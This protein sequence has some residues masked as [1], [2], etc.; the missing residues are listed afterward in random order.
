MS[1]DSN[2]TTLL[3]TWTKTTGHLFR[4]TVAAN[5]AVLATAGRQSD[6][7][8]TSQE[9]VT[10]IE[11]GES[12]PEWHVKLSEDHPE[13]LDIG[14][15]I[16]FTKT[17]TDDD[18]RS[19]AAASGDTNPLHLDDEYVETTRFRECLAHGVLVGS[20]I[21][22]AV[23]RLPGVAVYLSQ[24]FEFH[25]P[26]YPDDRLTATIEI[27]E[28]LGDD[29]YRLTTRVTNDSETVIDGEAV[30]LIDDNSA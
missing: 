24:N 16:E 21:S 20:L 26:A 13:Q 12:L 27:V 18:I 2:A 29:Q 5:Q 28:A 25:A 3:E 22:A 30:V 8:G 1:S 6:G 17:I 4:S 15:R 9:P 19:F 23:A 11:A 14:D 10:R 7:D